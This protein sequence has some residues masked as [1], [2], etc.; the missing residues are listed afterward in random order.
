MLENPK[1]YLTQTVIGNFK[2]RGYRKIEKINSMTHVEKLKVV[3]NGQ[4]AEKLSK[5]IYKY[6]RL[7]TSTISPRRTRDGVL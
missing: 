5:F 3:N 1:G 2:L 4:S 7:S 6:D